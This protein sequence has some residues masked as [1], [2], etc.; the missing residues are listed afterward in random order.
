MTKLEKLR[1][2]LSAEHSIF[3]NVTYEDLVRSVAIRTLILDYDILHFFSDK[4]PLGSFKKEYADK[5]AEEI[6]KKQ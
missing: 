6:A 4:S 3:K 2:T 1:E 5:R